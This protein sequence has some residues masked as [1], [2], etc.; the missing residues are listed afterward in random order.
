MAVV[1]RP[2]VEHGDELDQRLLLSPQGLADPGA[3][4]ADHRV[5]ALG[6]PQRGWQVDR[7]FDPRGRDGRCHD[8]GD[9]PGGRNRRPERRRA[10]RGLGDGRI[11]GR[12]DGLGALRARDD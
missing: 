4:F 12:A 10:G 11:A 1:T 8:V 9:W 5:I 6:Q 3:G 2:R 7:Q